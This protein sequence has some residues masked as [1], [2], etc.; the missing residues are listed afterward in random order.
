MDPD[1]RIANRLPTLKV[2]RRESGDAEFGDRDR[3][4]QNRGAQ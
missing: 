2:R 4:A 3:N 1:V